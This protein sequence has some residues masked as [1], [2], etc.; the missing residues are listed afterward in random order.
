VA[1]E[2]N[3]PARR[4]VS[5]PDFQAALTVDDG[6]AAFPP[7]IITA[8]HR[9]RSGEFVSGLLAALALGLVDKHPET[10]LRPAYR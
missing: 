3:I 8:W 5:H 6:P 9:A 10:G 1:V 4:N 2:Y 7:Q